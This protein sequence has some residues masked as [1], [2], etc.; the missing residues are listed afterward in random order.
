[1]CDCKIVMQ[2]DTVYSCDGEQV[3]AISIHELHLLCTQKSKQAL[4]Q[5]KV[6]NLRLGYTGE[7]FSQVTDYSTVLALV[8]KDQGKNHLRCLSK[9]EIC[10]IADLEQEIIS[11]AINKGCTDPSVLFGMGKCLL[12]AIDWDFLCF[13]SWDHDNIYL[14]KASPSI[15]EMSVLEFEEIFEQHGSKLG[16]TLYCFENTETNVFR[17]EY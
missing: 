8:Y 5:R 13:V 10:I 6:S 7:F 14:C 11:I 17:L 3:G 15:C 4:L 9:R 12:I 2:G 1:M 16:D